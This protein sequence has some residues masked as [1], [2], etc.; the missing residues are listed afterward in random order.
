MVL[1]QAVTDATCTSNN[2]AINLTVN[3]GTP[4]FTYAWT[5]PNSFASDIED[6]VNLAPG[7]YN[8]TVTDANGC[9]SNSSA[10]VKRISIEPNLV[11]HDI[12]I[13]SPANLT[14]PFITAGSDPGLVYS[15]W[16]D[17]SATNAVPDPKAVPTGTYYIKGTNADGC[18]SIKPVNVT[19]VPSP[20]FVVTN[21]A[22]VCEP[23]TVDLTDPVITAGSDPQL[24]FTYWNDA[25][26]TI[27]LANPQAVGVSGTYFI[28]ATATGGCSF[29]KAVE[30]VVTV[31]KGE[32]SVRYPTVV[33]S[34]NVSTQLNAREVGLIN[35]YTWNPPVGL[36][37]YNRKN[38]IFRYDKNTEYTIRIDYGND[39]PVI[40]TLL[41]LLNQ[42]IPGC[43]SGI[44]VPKAWS[45]NNDGHNDKL[46]PIP[47]C[48]R[49][50]KYFRVFNR[51]GQLVFE[52]NVLYHGWDGIFKGQPQVMDVYTW[53][54]EATG[55]DGKFYK[56][57]GNSVL[58]R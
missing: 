37:A 2:G 10:T 53:T 22:R 32:K 36:N 9:T 3:S 1:N 52:T 39:C 35:N 50:L 28:K 6:P 51:W 49:E 29:V 54:L 14:E 33:T 26:T 20:L 34:A 45:P 19:V 27:P 17:V 18:Y 21:P 44:Y 46:Y 55:E 56:Q 13:C 30:V 40:D 58:L 5:G 43:V 25:A 12:T 4:P 31:T 8:V 41:V 42:D 15:Y 57:E 7:T 47:V 38:P 11:T 23:E 48:I 24:T 16:R